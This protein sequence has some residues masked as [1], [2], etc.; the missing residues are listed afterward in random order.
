MTKMK[1]SPDA[2]RVESFETAK[3]TGEQGTVHA[4]ASF[5]CTRFSCNTCNDS[6]TCPIASM[7]EY[8]CANDC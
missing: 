3:A 2:L 1:L 7:C 4:H 6:C 8:S 5:G